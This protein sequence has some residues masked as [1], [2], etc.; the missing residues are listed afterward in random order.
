VDHAYRQAEIEHKIDRS[1]FSKN[2]QPSVITEEPAEKCFDVKVRDTTLNA[3]WNLRE[4]IN[5]T[6]YPKE[7]RGQMSLIRFN[8]QIPKEAP[9]SEEH[10][11]EI[12]E[13]ANNGLLALVRGGYYSLLMLDMPPFL[14]DEIT[15]DLLNSAQAAGIRASFL[16]IVNAVK[17]TQSMVKIELTKKAITSSL[18]AISFLET[19][20]DVGRFGMGHDSSQKRLVVTSGDIICDLLSGD[21]RLTMLYPV[22]GESRDIKVIYDPLVNKIPSS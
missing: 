12:R 3:C 10:C 9:F 8:G 6:N 15:S 7:W 19:Q 20:L 14:S 17:S 2:V 4:H 22:S 13:Q 18:G 11:Q 5:I 21:A 1:S 16:T